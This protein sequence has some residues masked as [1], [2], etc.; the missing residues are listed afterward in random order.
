MVTSAAGMLRFREASGSVR[1]V[2]ASMVKDI[3]ARPLDDGLG[4]GPCVSRIML[5][6]GGEAYSLDGAEDLMDQYDSIIDRAA[7]LNS[8]VARNSELIN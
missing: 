2:E 4:H 8:G 6:D 7:M 1:G 5:K 3:G